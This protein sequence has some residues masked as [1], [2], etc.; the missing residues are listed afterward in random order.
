MG[1]F[2]QLILRV[3]LSN[4]NPHPWCFWCPPLP[5]AVHIFFSDCLYRELRSIENLL[6]S[7]SD[8]QVSNTWPQAQGDL[9][10]CA[11]QRSPTAFL[12][13]IPFPLLVAKGES[14]EKQFLIAG[15]SMFKVSL[16]ILHFCPSKILFP[17]CFNLFLV[18]CPDPAPQERKRV[19]DSFE[20]GVWALD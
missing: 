8:A 7:L 13:K 4:N 16:S 17:L 5:V 15:W 6:V 10:R 9:W 11:L 20:G 12:G 19:L 18:W 3:M 2:F 1:S 14:L